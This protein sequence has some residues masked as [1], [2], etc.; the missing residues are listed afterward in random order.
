MMI[1]IENNNNLQNDVGH[2]TN[3]VVIIFNHRFK[4]LKNRC[5]KRYDMYDFLMYINRKHEFTIEYNIYS[6]I[7]LKFNDTT[8]K[9]KLI[10]SSV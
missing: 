9:I 3:W 6:N 4:V 8:F 2:D 1:F 10:L 5:K 7:K